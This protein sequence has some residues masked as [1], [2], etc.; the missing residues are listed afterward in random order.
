MKYSGL[1]N[2]EQKCMDVC[3]GV[4][5]FDEYNTCVEECMFQCAVVKEVPANLS[6]RLG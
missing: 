4:S 1:L 5:G 2:C 6:R 3:S